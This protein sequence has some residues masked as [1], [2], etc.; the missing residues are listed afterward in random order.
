M[1][2]LQNAWRPLLL[3]LV[4]LSV[5]VGV[6]GAVPTDQPSALGS[7]RQLVISAADFY[8][9]SDDMDYY[10]VGNWLY[11][12]ANLTTQYFLA[13]VDF[14]AP[15]WVTID[16]FELFAY[17]NNTAGAISAHLKLTKPSQGTEQ[18]M[19]SIDTGTT[20][21]STDN[22]HTWQT[23]AISPNVKNPANDLY[24]YLLIT[25][26]DTL[27]LRGVRIWYRVGQ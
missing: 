2:R 21:A 17:D 22:P 7:Q 9:Y 15:N 5:L 26:N 18:I 3:G 11:S 24:V 27:W 12:A 1:N 19:A 10:N 25:D 13:P 4:L 23:T 14:P 20:Y 8:P 6:A 16:K